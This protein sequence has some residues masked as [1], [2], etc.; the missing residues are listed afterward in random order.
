M[1]VYEP[2]NNYPAYDQPSYQN[3]QFSNE[4][5]YSNAPQNNITPPANNNLPPGYISKY[6]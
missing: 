5:S 2:S 3:Q 6:W 4:P 1:P